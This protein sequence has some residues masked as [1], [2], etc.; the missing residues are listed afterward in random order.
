MKKVNLKTKNRNKEYSR[1]V[2]EYAK[3]ISEYNG[4]IGVVVGGGI[5]RGYSDE[6]SDIDLY[7]F[8]DVKTYRIWKKKGPIP[9]GDH[10]YK[11]YWIETEFFDYEKEVKTVWRI[12]D[13]WER[14]NHIILFDANSK[15][16]DLYKKKLIFTQKE[17]QDM[18]E[19]IYD[20]TAWY[21]A[22]LPNTWIKRGDLAQAHY[23]MNKG[24]D[25][26]IEYVFLQN[27]Y[28]TPW[29]K[30]KI[31]YAFLMDKLPSDFKKNILE[32]MKIKEFTEKDVFR[33]QR[34]LI[35]ILKQLELYKD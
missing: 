26:I 35:K 2:K 11:E 12:E 10:Y 30:W 22:E 3:K 14:K 25:W 9:E 32:A 16:N 34:I 29:G 5:G 19:E 20:K 8:L 27:N 31:H 6:F 13:R 15:I 24:I 17:K 23:V 4:V 7:V 28:F 21:I 18:Y 1:I 33:R